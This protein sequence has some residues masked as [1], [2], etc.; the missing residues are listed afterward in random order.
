VLRKIACAGILLTAFPVSIQ[1]ECFPNIAQ[2]NALR[3]SGESFLEPFDWF[4]EWFASKVKRLVMHRHDVLSASV[5]CHPDSLF[6]GAM[7]PDPGI[8]GADRHDPQVITPPASQRA[9]RVRHR[10]VATEY[11][12]LPFPRN[13]VAI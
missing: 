7:R 10:G 9:K 4:L 3:F 6:R 2:S 8:V 1:N 11:D 5:V 12:L 13:D